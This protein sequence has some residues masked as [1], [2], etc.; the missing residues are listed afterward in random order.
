MAAYQYEVKVNGKSVWT[1]ESDDYN[2]IMHFPEEYRDRPKKGHVDLI[3]NGE[4][5]GHQTP[6]EPGEEEA[7]RAQRKIDLGDEN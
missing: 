2:G 3:L 6:L 7:I 1:D 4:I 5:I